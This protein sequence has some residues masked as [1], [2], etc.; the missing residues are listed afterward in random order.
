MSKKWIAV[1]IGVYILGGIAYVG[2]KN[3]NNSTAHPNP[4]TIL[5]DQETR[6]GAPSSYHMS[7][8]VEQPGKG[9]FEPPYWLIKPDLEEHVE[10]MSHDHE[11]A[12]TTSPDSQLMTFFSYLQ[13]GPPKDLNSFINP[14]I[15]YQDISAKDFHHIEAKLDELG[16]EISRGK[17]IKEVYLSDPQLSEDKAS[18]DVKI[19]YQD[20]KIV[21]LPKLAMVSQNEVKNWFIDM[22]LSEL[23]SQV[24]RSIMK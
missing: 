20:G 12:K 7:W 11:H 14:D 10:E 19:V 16:N 3:V 4:E 8:F 18:Y 2:T 21:Q 22:R 23:A 13:L 6:A 24:K 15:S 17:T 9:N 1:I 5:S